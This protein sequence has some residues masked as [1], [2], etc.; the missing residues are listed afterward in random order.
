MITVLEPLKMDE[1]L[2]DG[3]EPKAPD[4]SSLL[5]NIENCKARVRYEAT[6]VEALK[7]V[8]SLS[9]RPTEITRFH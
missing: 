4:K 8:C 3:M 9:F 6:A 2:K 1:C 7:A 5:Y